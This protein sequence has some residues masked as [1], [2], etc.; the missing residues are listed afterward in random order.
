MAS[1]FE[2]LLNFISW[3]LNG[4]FRAEARQDPSLAAW[5]SEDLSAAAFTDTPIGP[6]PQMP[7]RP[8][9]EQAQSQVAGLQ[10]IDPD[11]SDIAFVA[12]AS[13]EYM[14]VFAAEGA[15]NVDSI[16]GIVTPDF[17]QR[18]RK[19]IEDWN[20]SGYRRVTKDLKLDGGTVFKVAIEGDTQDITVRFVGSAVRYT[21]DLASGTAVE[22]SMQPESFTEFVG[23]E[24]PAGSTTPKPVAAGG[25]SHCPACGAPATEGSV[26]CSFCGT[27]L[28]GT[29]GNWRLDKISL[30]AYT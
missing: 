13:K 2:G 15:M 26:Y 14:A 16:S 11:F 9:W 18:L 29:G 19:R 5:A 28:A 12:Q 6:S 7:A 4:L 30:S 1:F 24:R 27:P 10:K 22:G 8:L 21:Q 3:V 17:L 23:F 20:G 25:P